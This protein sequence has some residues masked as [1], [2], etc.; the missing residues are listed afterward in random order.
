MVIMMGKPLSTKIGEIVGA[1]SDPIIVYPGGWGDTLPEWLKAAITV[2]RLA[3][4][5][6]AL[7]GE[8]ITGT[9]AEVCAYLYTAGLCFPFDHDWA[10]ICF[11]ITGQVYT[12]HRTKESGTLVPEDIRVESLNDEQ[13]RDLR[14]LKDSIYKRRTQARLDR[15][16]AERRQEKEE[17]AARKKREQ[18]TLFEF[19]EGG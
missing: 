7:R 8:E 10:E 3:M 13:M 17:V 4:N 19:L 5:I 9:D 2:E 14:R 11:Y 18:P 12:R 6:R 1:L 15:E 16:R